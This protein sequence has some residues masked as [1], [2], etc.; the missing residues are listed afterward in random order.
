MCL[1]LCEKLNICLE[2]LNVCVEKLTNMCL[3]PNRT[4]SLPKNKCHASC[5]SQDNLQIMYLERKPQ[6]MCLSTY[7]KLIICVETLNMCVEKLNIRVEFNTCI[8]N[9]NSKP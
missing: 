4:V 7:G 5:F 6:Y 1:K 3:N 9:L 8:S 2:K